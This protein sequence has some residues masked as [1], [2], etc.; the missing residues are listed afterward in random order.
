MAVLDWLAGWRTVSGCVVRVSEAYSAFAPFGLLDT[1]MESGIV[2]QACTMV[3]VV[4][5]AAHYGERGFRSVGVVKRV[6]L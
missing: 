4:I 1:S 2:S 6:V 3:V 5:A